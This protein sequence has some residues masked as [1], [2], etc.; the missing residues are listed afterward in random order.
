MVAIQAS[1]EVAHK[2]FGLYEVK[3]LEIRI[4]AKNKRFYI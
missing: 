3:F 4:Y 1:N 2:H